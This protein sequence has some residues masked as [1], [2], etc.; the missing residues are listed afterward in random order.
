MFRFDSRKMSPVRGQDLGDAKTFGKGNNGGI[1]QSDIEIGIGLHDLEASAEIFQGYHFDGELALNKRFYEG[2]F[3]HGSEIG[4]KHITDFRDNGGRCDYPAL[5]GFDEAERPLMPGI[6]FIGQGNY[7]AGVDQDL[8]G[9]EG[10]AHKNSSCFSARSCRP[11]SPILIKENV[12]AGDFL[13][14]RY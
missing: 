1:H 12:G 3:R 5:V 2:F 10:L 4:V 8:I 11:L 13:E 7:N 9:L 6:T 14:W